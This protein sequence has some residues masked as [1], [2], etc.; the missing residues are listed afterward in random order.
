[1]N[2]ISVRKLA[3]GKLS[4]RKLSLKK[5]A[6][7][8]LMLAL[9]V[10]CTALLSKE[11]LQT[12]YYTL[13]RAQSKPQ[14]APILNNNTRLPILIVN[15][16]KAAP[17]F[18]TQRM[19]YTRAPHQLE[20]FARNEWV[21]TP[22]HMLRPLM[23]SAIEKT[24]AFNAVLD[25]Q[26]VVASDLRLESEIIKLVQNFNNKPSNNKPSLNKPSLNKPS[27]VQFTLRVTMIDNVTNKVIALQEFDERVDASSDNP[28]GGAA[29]ANVAVNQV[30]NNLSLFTQ[31]IVINW[32]KSNGNLP[33]NF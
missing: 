18:D 30:L 20:Y 8:I 15:T 4:A 12:T 31:Q 33:E 16:P 17:G 21:D 1:M 23:I 25:K 13:E 6:F 2:H 3:S 22:A 26:S 14:S 28:M 27:Y 10:S 29:A 32:G 11:P 19:I 5:L 9:Q 24:G 7:F